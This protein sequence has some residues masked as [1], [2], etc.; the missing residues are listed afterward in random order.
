MFLKKACFVGHSARKKP[1]DIF[2]VGIRMKLFGRPLCKREVSTAALSLL[3]SIRC[4]RKV[5]WQHL[6]R[7]KNEASDWRRNFSL[8]TNVAACH[9]VL[10]VNT[11]YNW[12]RPIR[13][14]LRW[15]KSRHLIRPLSQ[16]FV[17]MLVHVGVTFR[18][19][20]VDLEEGHHVGAGPHLQNVVGAL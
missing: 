15:W 4:K 18:P 5:R 11:I 3:G 12:W 20:A 7:T 1:H 8:S 9:P 6:S 17:E 19:E 14:G 13:T 10:V 2:Q 16:D